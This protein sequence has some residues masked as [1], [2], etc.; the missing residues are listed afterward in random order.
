MTAP[1]SEKENDEHTAQAR[2]SLQKKAFAQLREMI[3]LQE[4]VPGSLVSEAT[5]SKR[6]GLG[7]SPI[8]AALHRLALE[9]LVVI[10]PQRGIMVT[11]INVV[12][13]LKLLEVR[14]E[15][16]RLVIR[17]AA[18]R[19]TDAQ[20]ARMRQLA[21]H[22]EAA[23]AD[24]DGQRFMAILKDIH[25]LTDEA[26][27][28][29]I[30][31]NVISL[32]HGLSRRF[33]FAHY[34][35]YGDLQLAARLHASRLRATADGDLDRAAACSDELVAYLE[36]FTRSTIELDRDSRERRQRASA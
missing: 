16:E 14:A 7:R 20:R 26:A 21:D 27:D 15:L 3:V 18:K 28:N 17:S 5:L 32:V 19:A 12:T 31:L 22:I 30:L 34:Q 1:A 24:A 6:L 9:G 4:L 29:E 13:Q 33:W 35:K 25:S 11:E 36:D 8:R 2:G 10:L 23:A